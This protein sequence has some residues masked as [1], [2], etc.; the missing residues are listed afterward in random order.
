MPC[1]KDLPSDILKDLDKELKKRRPEGRSKEDLSLEFQFWD[2][3]G[4][5][6]YYNMHQVGSCISF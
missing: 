6:V 3:A 5:D 2:F 1:Y 4:Q